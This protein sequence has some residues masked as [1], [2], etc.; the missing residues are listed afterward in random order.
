MFGKQGNSRLSIEKAKPHF[1]SYVIY[2][3]IILNDYQNISLVCK[4]INVKYFS[5]S[6][7]WEGGG[8]CGNRGTDDLN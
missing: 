3:A 2:V 5:N 7:P 4:F 6:I 8:F 1:A